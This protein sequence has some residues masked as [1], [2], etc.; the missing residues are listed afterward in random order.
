M[1]NN[2]PKP[3]ESPS[4]HERESIYDETRHMVN[5]LP[6][7][8]TMYDGTYPA[9]EEFTSSL[10]L[11][12][13]VSELSF[14]SESPDSGSHVHFQNVD[15]IIELPSTP[16]KDGS[17]QPEECTVYTDTE[18]ISQ[19]TIGA[20]LEK[21][22]TVLMQRSLENRLA[23]Q[24]EQMHA[25]MGNEDE[26]VVL[27]QHS[28]RAMASQPAFTK[29]M[30]RDFM[31]HSETMFNLVHGTNGNSA[32]FVIGIEEAEAS[33]PDV[34]GCSHRPV[35]R[36]I[37]PSVT[38][39]KGENEFVGCFSKDNDMVLYK[40]TMPEKPKMEREDRESIDSLIAHHAQ[41]LVEA[42]KVTSPTVHVRQ[43]NDDNMLALLTFSDQSSAVLKTTSAM[44]EGITS[45][46]EL[47]EAI[48]STYRQLVAKPDEMIS[49]HT[50]TT[51]VS[52]QQQPAFDLD[53]PAPAHRHQLRPGVMNN[54][55]SATSSFGLS[56]ESTFPMVVQGSSKNWIK[57]PRMQHAAEVVLNLRL[58]L[59]EY[60]LRNI[61]VTGT[62][63]K[64]VSHVLSEVMR[65]TR[66]EVGDEFRRLGLVDKIKHVH[67]ELLMPHS[68][69]DP[70][71]IVNQLRH[72]IEEIQNYPLKARS[73]ASGEE[74][75]N[76]VLQTLE[77]LSCELDHEIEHPEQFIEALQYGLVRVSET[78][79]GSCSVPEKKVVSINP[80]PV[81]TGPAV[82]PTSSSVL[83][84]DRYEAPSVSFCKP[85][86][87]F[88][89]RIVLSIWSVLVW[90]MNQMNS[91]W[92][93]LNSPP[94]PLLGTP[95]PSVSFHR[96]VLDNE[97]IPHQRHE[98]SN[99]L[100]Q[101]RNVLQIALER[102]S[103]AEITADSGNVPDHS[104]NAR[105]LKMF[106]QL[107]QD[108]GSIELKHSSSRHNIHLQ[109]HTS[110]SGMLE[111]READD[112]LTMTG[113]IRDHDAGVAVFFDARIIDLDS[114]AKVESVMECVTRIGR[115]SDDVE[116]SEVLSE[117][118]VVHSAAGTEPTTEDEQVVSSLIEDM[119]CNGGY[120][121][122]LPILNTT[123]AE[124]LLREIKH[125]L[126]DLLS[127]VTS[128]VHKLCDQFGNA[129]VGTAH[130]MAEE[131]ASERYTVEIHEDVTNEE[132][133][134]ACTDHSCVICNRHV[135]TSNET[136]EN[137]IGVDSTPALEQPA[138]ELPLADITG[139][140]VDEALSPPQKQFSEHSQ[141][142][143]TMQELLQLFHAT[144]DR[145]ETID[146]DISAIRN[147]VQQL[148]AG[149]QQQQ[150]QPVPEGTHPP[151]QTE[152]RRAQ[153]KS[154]AQKLRK[155]Y[156]APIVRCPMQTQQPIGPFGQ[157]GSY[158]PTEIYSCHAVSPDVLVVHW[159]VLD[160]DVLHC[161]AGFEIYVDNELRS[162]C[163]SNKRR[164]TLVGN[165]D[166]KKHH[167]ITLNIMPRDDLGSACE[168]TA[169][170]AP[171]FFLYHT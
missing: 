162:V 111:K 96:S 4:A 130:T 31:E 118:T 40:R 6:I 66:Q 166:L 64:F 103:G 88:F 129:G 106:T 32:Q 38:N 85:Y 140:E 47:N 77:K 49:M 152:R 131:N 89:E 92:D 149:Q 142:A 94:P 98:E 39:D 10:V 100:N 121:E 141:L 7:S 68:L 137:E 139:I 76:R 134:H 59:E 58:L 61:S 73:L 43:D 82:F 86:T 1:Q 104:V 153:R 24:L 136:K 9:Y 72:T 45:E 155:S 55:S 113:N 53:R 125:C 119:V 19:S 16:L 23:Q 158:C 62:V 35:R 84:I 54:L 108:A 133:G 74:A 33:D 123:G 78:C 60:I 151:T 147:E 20:A 110:V 116:N 44:T 21:S 165:I 75:W 99:G 163:Y 157:S 112:Y 2:R 3:R 126:Q 115:L 15:P 145:L 143:E 107:L 168:K 109:L 28:I 27:K 65:C 101:A 128:A 25:M 56:N 51:P 132:E 120:D 34:P 30:L 12:S 41:C 70:V 156:E 93:F 105:S 95:S 13:S 148:V 8:P 5:N 67:N 36:S 17:R 170:W 146:T 26:L 50:Q 90:I 154:L 79:T 161:I 150:Q 42:D 80:T 46:D 124:Q 102:S 138:E 87:C 69:E 81:A 37:V 135:S 169:Q 164:T 48:L 11:Q 127:P 52:G 14:S 160:D 91:F 97:K 57:C 144:N 22:G 171:A 114:L 83:E 63:L 71:T 18:T 117:E 167:Q 159:R 122:E 29:D